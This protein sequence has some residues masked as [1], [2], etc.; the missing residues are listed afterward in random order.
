MHGGLFQE[1]KTFQSRALMI[2]KQPGVSKYAHFR[3]GGSSFPLIRSAMHKCPLE[4]LFLRN[5]V[6]HLAIGTK[7]AKIAYWKQ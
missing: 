1:Q 3:I 2:S 6:L 5:A 7:I 4:T